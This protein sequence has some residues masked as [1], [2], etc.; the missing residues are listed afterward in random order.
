M[1]DRALQKRGAVLNRMPTQLALPQDRGEVRSQRRE[2]LT[3]CYPLRVEVGVR[4]LGV[5]ERVE[6]DQK[7][8]ASEGLASSLHNVLP[9]NF[10]ISCEQI[11]A[12]RNATGL[13]KEHKGEIWFLSGKL[14]KCSY[15][16]WQKASLI[17]REIT[18]RTSIKCG[19][20]NSIAMPRACKSCG[21]F[22]HTRL[23]CEKRKQA[24]AT[25]IRY[26]YVLSDRT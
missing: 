14:A 4:L 17:F 7:Q 2:Q 11:W 21:Y 18:K 10:P 15:S 16:E 3:A 24:E 13:N 9:C 6:W 8:A 19:P 1:A 20:M 23:H 25:N 5:L 22:G 12:S 26:S